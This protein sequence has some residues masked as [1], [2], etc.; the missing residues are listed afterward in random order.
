MNMMCFLFDIWS[1]GRATEGC[2][3]LEILA[4]GDL[5]DFAGSPSRTPSGICREYH[6]VISK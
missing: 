4:A 5:A 1:R 6:L 2:Q 3:S